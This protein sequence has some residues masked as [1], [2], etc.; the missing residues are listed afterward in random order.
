MKKFA[1]SC[2]TALLSVTAWGQT[3]HS[4]EVAK[5]L[6]ILNSLYR[7]LDLYFVDSLEAD[8]L[9][10]TG[11]DA[12][13][14]SLDPYTEYF[15]EEDM[16]DLK[17]MTTGK[18]GGIGSVIRLRKDST[19]IISEPYSGMPAAEVGLKVGDVILKIDDKEITKGMMTAEVSDM[20]RGE[21]GTTFVLKVQRPGEK[22][23]REFKITRRNIKVD[24]IQ[25]FDLIDENTGYIALNTFTEGCSKEMRKAII[26][27]KERG[28]KQLIIDLRGNGGGLLNEAVDIVNLFVPKDLTI[29]Q[30]KGK[31]M[32]SNHTYVTK[33]D[34]LDLEIPIVVLVSGN[35]A[36][37]AEILSG[38]LQDLDRAVVVGAKTFGKGLVQSTMELPYNT[39]VKLTTAKY[40][41]P[42]G[43]CVQAIDYKRLR[44]EAEAKRR[45]KTLAPKD[46]L[47]NIFHT[48]G[49]R[50]VKE[51]SGIMPDV[52]VKHD[53]LANIVFYLST[54]DVLLDWG[55]AYCQ[56]HESIPEVRDFAITD[57][58][59]ND[60]KQMAKDKDF[61]F[62]RQSEKRLQDLKK[63]AQ[64]EGYYDD[65]KAEFEALEAKL[66]HNLDREMD[67]HKKDIKRL[68]A[69][70]VV[71]R[72]YFQAGAAEEAI[73]GDEDVEKALKLINDSDAYKKI[74]HP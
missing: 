64:F 19:V 39:S 58:D 73:K 1:L 52:V 30:T 27:L 68:M 65:A 62:D 67:S 72:Y 9:I 22:K 34:P 49:G 36:S 31:V 11:I 17:Q 33:N 3:E 43:R 28:A 66:A 10:T 53:T 56:K 55:T 40:Y 21:P 32:A 4:F 71:K 50:E 23:P 59:F 48:A 74:L 57:E 25:Y 13:L 18:Y 47:S 42:S 14:E 45:G 63:T 35:T 2:L 5:N 6:D 44:D 16:S 46:T 15:A 70:E 7:Q 29:V 12:M 8:K 61:K 69:Q 26:S 24:A 38:S 37:A 54:D 41:I 20:L 60:L 51:G